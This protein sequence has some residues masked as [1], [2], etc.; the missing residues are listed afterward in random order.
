MD[1]KK[2]LLALAGGTG[3]ALVS[4]SL[5]AQPPALLPEQFACGGDP[6]CAIGLQSS[7][8]TVADMLANG[9]KVVAG[10]ETRQDCGQAAGVEICMDL[11][12]AVL[13]NA[14]SDAAVLVCAAQSPV[15]A[16]VTLH[17]GDMPGVAMVST[18]T[19]VAPWLPGQLSEA[20]VSAQARAAYDTYSPLQASFSIRW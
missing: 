15:A 1:K 9:Y 6:A 14:H 17:C 16:S 11:S 2:A 13:Y 3:L 8:A 18:A 5:T 19:A 20:L 4:A 7:R 10:P 12:A